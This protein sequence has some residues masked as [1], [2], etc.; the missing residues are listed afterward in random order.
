MMLDTASVMDCTLREGVCE[1]RISLAEAVKVT[2]VTF[3]AGIRYIEIADAEV[4][5]VMDIGLYELV[6]KVVQAVPR[7][8]I[9]VMV[10][11]SNSPGTVKRIVEAGAAFI[12]VGVNNSMAEQAFPLI[13]TAKDLGA[14]VTLNALKIYTWSDQEIFS[15]ARDAVEAGAD[16]I[17]VVDSA[18]CM[19][20]KAVARLTR[21]VCDLGVPTGFHGHDNFSLAIANSLAALDVG[22]TVVDGTLRGIGRS[23]GNA[24][25]EVLVKA[26]QKDGYFRDVNGDQLAE[27]AEVLIANRRPRDRGISY[28][29]VVMG[30][31]RF[32]SDRLDLV[33]EIAESFSVSLHS[34]IREVGRRDP[35]T[36]S[37]ALVESAA[38]YLRAGK[39]L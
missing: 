11:A 9:G 32:H 13:E 31:G 37:R 6:E 8:C 26:A 27:L 10:G 39:T 2:R 34:L 21:S 7:A 23:A 1:I 22:A 14:I 12:R 16:V 38:L 28:L 30:E 25:I 36:P 24:Q 17:Y 19:L 3:E 33:Q 29:D 20:P 4:P 5:N 18:G 15:V 35:V